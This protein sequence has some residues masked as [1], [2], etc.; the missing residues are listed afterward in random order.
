MSTLK[1]DTI[2]DSGGT[3][4]GFIK[5]VVSTHKS[6]VYSESFTSLSE[7]SNIT[8]FSVSITPFYQQQSSAYWIYE[9]WQ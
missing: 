3:A 8:G 5:Q 4:Y 9:C 1:V 6:D 7:G 2:Q